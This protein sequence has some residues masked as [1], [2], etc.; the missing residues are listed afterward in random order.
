MSPGELM[1]WSDLLSDGKTDDDFDDL[2]V[3]VEVEI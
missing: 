2:A 3:G 1:E